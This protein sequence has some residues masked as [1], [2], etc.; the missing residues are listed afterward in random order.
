LQYNHLS[1]QIL[2]ICQ[3]NTG[4]WQLKGT[5]DRTTLKTEVFIWTVLKGITLSILIAS[6]K[7]NY[8]H[9]D[10]LCLRTQRELCSQPTVKCPMLSM[11]LSY[12]RQSRPCT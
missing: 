10:R 8:Q 7:W 12:K 4:S 9:R 1:Y 2:W 11:F 5:W 6:I 3:I